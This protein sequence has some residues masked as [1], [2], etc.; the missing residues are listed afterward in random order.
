MT[1]IALPSSGIHAGVPFDVYRQWPAV[2]ISTLKGMR[3][4]ALHCRWE[5]DTPKESDEMDVGS[6]THI[7]LLEPQRFDREFYLGT[8]EYNATTK[9]GRAMKDKELEIANGRT[10][11]RRKAGKDAV[12]ADDV[13]GMISAVRSFDAPSKFMNMP[14]QCE[15]SML[16]QDPYTGLMCKARCDKVITAS[17]PIIFELKSCRCADSREFGKQAHDMGYAAQ[18]AFYRWGYQVITGVEPL[19]LFLAI[20]NKGPWA[21]KLHRL[22]NEGLQF[23]IQ[24]F[25]GWLDKFAECQKTGRWPGYP[26]LVEPLSL[27]HWASAE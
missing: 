12:D 13:R 4:T 18:A 27:P 9:E 22:E 7:A 24:Q 6:A 11:I 5:M 3:R 21:A 10:L 8:E 25:R 19:H 17:R 1:P 15:V 20:E 14:G 23:G 2:N 26:D 16:W